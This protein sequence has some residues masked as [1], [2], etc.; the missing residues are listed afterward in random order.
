MTKIFD[1]YPPEFKEAYATFE[2]FRRLGFPPN[3]M[4]IHLRP[5]GVFFVV[6]QHLGKEFA[7]SISRSTFTEKELGERF[8]ELARRIAKM[9]LDEEE[10]QD[11]WKN[12]YIFK[13]RLG[14]LIAMA[15]KGLRPLA[16][17]N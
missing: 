12:S 15:A 6:L 2:F 9:E 13:N 3:S 14:A 5:D 7:V 11:A 4:F 1:E 10:L 16:H 8:S 17:L